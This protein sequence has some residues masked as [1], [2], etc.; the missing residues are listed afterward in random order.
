[1]SE[2]IMNA[3]SIKTILYHFNLGTGYSLSYIEAI[4]TIFGLLCIWFASQEKIINF[5]FGLINVTLF[6]IIFYQIQLYDNLMLQIYFFV[7]Y[8]Y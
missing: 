3:L 2:L 1:M 8:V 5:W 7:M 6:A 4:G